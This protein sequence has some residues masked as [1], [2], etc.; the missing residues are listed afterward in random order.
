MTTE[1]INTELYIYH[2]D[3]ELLSKLADAL[4]GATLDKNST[5]DLAKEFSSDGDELVEELFK[6]DQVSSFDFDAG[7]DEV[8]GYFVLYLEQE[9]FGDVHMVHFI[10]FLYKLIP[11]IHAQA[12]GYTEE[13]PWEFFIKYEDG[14]AI[15]QEHVPWE[16]EKM[17]DNAL[18]Y[19]YSWWHEDL[20]EEI[21]A[22]LLNDEGDDEEDEDY[23]DEVDDWDSDEFDDR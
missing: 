1:P 17:D 22:G 5:A 16:D 11:G 4:D 23:D 20:P 15:K 18:E 13:E 19:I 7:V 3:D 10:D 2:E 6:Y 8:A 9:D 12:W 21:E 14:R